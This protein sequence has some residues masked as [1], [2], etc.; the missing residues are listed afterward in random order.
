MTSHPQITTFAKIALLPLGLLI[1]FGSFIH[2]ASE[3]GTFLWGI[4]AST[5]S[6]LDTH[7]VG[8]LADRGFKAEMAARQTLA[9]PEFPRLSDSLLSL[10]KASFAADPLEASSLRTIALGGMLQDDPAR[11]GQVMRLAEQLSKR[12]SITNLWLAQ[13]YLRDGDVEA[14]LASFDHA[15]RTSSRVREFAM[16]PVVEA[17]ASKESYLPLGKL[18]GARPEWEGAFWTEFARNPV[19]FANAVAFLEANRIPLERIPQE[20]RQ[21]LY[22]NLKRAHQYD[23]LFGLAALDPNLEANSAALSDGKFITEDGANPLGWAVYSEG[24]FAAHVQEKTGELQIDARAGSFGVAAERLIRGGRD[25]RLL[26]RMAEVVPDDMEI[27]LS[28]RCL[29]GDGGKLA[30]VKLT[31]GDRSGEAAL[32]MQRCRFASV[33]LSFSVEPGRRDVFVRVGRI[34]LENA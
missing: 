4:G 2:A 13:D 1:A 34:E 29:D 22:V 14:M 26:I 33:E 18:L 23:T 19:A 17:L 11:T 24:N 12:D 32:G 6:G 16:K 10:A 5:R 3:T 25:R 20:T 15:L 27:E 9:Q 31:P 21:R 8:V 30:S 7:I 28:V